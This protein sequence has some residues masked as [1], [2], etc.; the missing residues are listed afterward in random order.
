M[1]DLDDV[2]GKLGTS[3][4]PAALASIDAAVFAGLTR[5]R[6]AS[7]ATSGRVMGIAAAAALGIG[8]AA[9]ALPETAAQAAPALPPFGISATLAPSNLLGDGE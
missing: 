9:A 3:P 5:R 2:L 1:T 4:V 7:S 6:A 8:V